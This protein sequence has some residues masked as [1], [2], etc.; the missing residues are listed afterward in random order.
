MTRFIPLILFILILAFSWLGLQRDPH[1][2]SSSLINKAAP[3]FSQAQ[4]QSDQALTENVFKNKITLLTV[5]AT[6][7]IACHSEHA[8]LIDLARDYPIQLIGLNYKDDKTSALA[9]LTTHGNPF[10]YCLFDPLGKLAMDYGVT[11]S[12]EHFLIDQGGVVRY[13]YA[14]QLTPSVWQRE[15]LARIKQLEQKYG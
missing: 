7:C 4:L 8:Y 5:W 10:Q 12:P 11:G 9:W 14:G 15:F 2:L 13:K 3:S 1:H 6:W